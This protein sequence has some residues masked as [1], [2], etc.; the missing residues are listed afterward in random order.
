MSIYS[1]KEIWTSDDVGRKKGRVAHNNTLKEF[2][3]RHGGKD[4]R[5]LSM[6]EGRE[7]TE[8]NTKMR[9]VREGLREE[10]KNGL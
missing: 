3:E 8:T 7:I 9:I 1:P 5:K 10:N 6:I 2:I 4:I